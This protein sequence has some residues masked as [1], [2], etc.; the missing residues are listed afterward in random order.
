MQQKLLLTR[1][2]DAPR[3]TLAEYRAEGG[4]QALEGAPAAKAILAAVEQAN[5]RGRG[6]A[7]FPV[8]RKWRLAAAAASPEKHFVANGGEHEPGSKKDRFLVA[9]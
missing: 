4:Y 3:Q 2:P 1:A 8:A 6:G 5:Q 7:T 9:R